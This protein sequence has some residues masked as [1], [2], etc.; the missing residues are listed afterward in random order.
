MIE[1]ILM[2]VSSITPDPPES[3][4][5]IDVG[6]GWA[7]QNMETSSSGNVEDSKDACGCWNGH[8]VHLIKVHFQKLPESGNTHEM[9]AFIG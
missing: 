5:A 4:A 1:G 9:L 7:Q 8:N 2:P 6:V 3:W